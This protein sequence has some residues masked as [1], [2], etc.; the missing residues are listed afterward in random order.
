MHAFSQ[1][2]QPMTAA[3]APADAADAELTG[4]LLAASSCTASIPRLSLLLLLLLVTQGRTA[5]LLLQMVY[6]SLPLPL[7]SFSCCTAE[8]T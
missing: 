7:V 5:P 2:M 8:R 6:L 4:R 3:T 1:H